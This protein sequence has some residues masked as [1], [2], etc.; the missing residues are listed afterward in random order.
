YALSR[1]FDFA[2]A[3]PPAG[4]DMR[5]AIDAYEGFRRGA[6]AWALGNLVVDL[7]TM[8]IFQKVTLD[9]ARADSLSVI[10]RDGEQQLLQSYLGKGLSID[11]VELKTDSSAAIADWSKSLSSATTIYVE[12]PIAD[13]HSEVLD[14]IA[15]CG[16]RAKLRLGGVIPGAFPST[17]LVAFALKQLA[18]RRIAYKA[19]AG[20]HHPLRSIHPITDEPDSPRE[21]MHGFINLICASAHV[22]FGGESSTAAQ[23]LDEQNVQAWRV[24]SESIRWR[25]LEWS[26]DQ[27]CEVRDSFLIRIGS[28]SFDEP[29]HDLEVL[30]W[31]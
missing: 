10:A 4:M 15:K 16:A 19:T 23:I 17:E 5:V 22:W 18:D 3:F 14:S 12:M 24:E 6:D 27:L 25:S 13:S 31:L 28:C 29:L 8:H 26:A 20:L 11:M 21:L 1:L 30:G 7:H 9:R 2:G